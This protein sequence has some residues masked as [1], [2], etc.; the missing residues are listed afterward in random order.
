MPRPAKFDDIR[1]LG[2]TATLVADGGP[3]AA[4]IGAIA[5]AIGAPTGSI[6]HRFGSRDELLGRLW[7]AKAAYF[8]DAFA[9]ALVGPDARAAAIEAA[10][11]LPRCA[12]AD[13]E[14]ARIML[15]HRR[16]DFIGGGWPPEMTR[17]AERLGR[18]VTDLLREATARLFGS[19]TTSNR[20]RATFALLDVPLGAVRRHVAQNKPPPPEIDDL[21]AL[22]IGAI[23]DTETTQGGPT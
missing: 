9:R 13:F 23:L 20:R 21:I 10:L 12:R 22:A 19:E 4:T 11:S 7:L 5:R 16:E 3:S 15:L 2:A 17:E 6:Y 1:I 18:Q 8:Q 14:G